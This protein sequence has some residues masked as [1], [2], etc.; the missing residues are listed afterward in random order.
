MTETT[1][2]Y[3]TNGTPEA[4]APEVAPEITPAERIAPI[5]AWLEK[6]IAPIMARGPEGRARVE[7]HIKGERISA[8]LTLPVI[9]A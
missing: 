2:P 4:V 9:I 8:E 1:V 6:N 3:Q 5:V 7:L